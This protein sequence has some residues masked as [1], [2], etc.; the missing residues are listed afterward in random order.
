MKWI[1][2]KE[3]LPNISPGDPPKRLLVWVDPPKGVSRF[4]IAC[5]YPITKWDMS[6]VTHWAEI[7]PPRW[8]LKTSDS[9]F[10]PSRGPSSR[11][12]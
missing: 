9:N 12:T 8:N 7:K 5:Y 11:D 2:V 6:F 4:D 1:S 3:K 10:A